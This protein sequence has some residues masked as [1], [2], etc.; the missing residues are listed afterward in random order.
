MTDTDRQSGRERA[1]RDILFQLQKQP[2][3][4]NLVA[5]CRTGMVAGC[6]QVRFQQCRQVLGSICPMRDAGTKRKR[7]PAPVPR[8]IPRVRPHTSQLAEP[9]MPVPY[10]QQ[11]NAENTK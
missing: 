2:L 11:G 1:F 4:L 7:A 3:R 10:A 6:P 5:G 8:A 9:Q